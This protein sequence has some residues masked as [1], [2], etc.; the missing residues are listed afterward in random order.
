MKKNTVGEHIAKQ[1]EALHI[2]G[3]LKEEALACLKYL[4]LPKLKNIEKNLTCFCEYLLFL[5]QQN[6]ENFL[7]LTA[8]SD[9]KANT[10]TRD[11]SYFFAPKQKITKTQT[12]SYLQK[13]AEQGFHLLNL[14]QGIRG[15]LVLTIDEFCN[16]SATR[17][18]IHKLLMQGKCK[19]SACIAKSTPCK[20]STLKNK[21][22]KKTEKAD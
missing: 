4:T 8:G 5:N 17:I 7:L 13:I 22:P 10:S 11:L 1:I 16:A 14:M 21:K 12:K 3:Y 20:K 9:T 19:D 6:T 15:L 2:A 18:D